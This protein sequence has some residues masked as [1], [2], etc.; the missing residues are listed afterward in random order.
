M[1]LKFPVQADIQKAFVS[2]QACWSETSF[3]P[4]E[5]FDH[6][7]WSKQCF[8]QFHQL[9]TKSVFVFVCG[10]K[11]DLSDPHPQSDPYVRLT[12]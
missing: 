11:T 9:F 3:F 1:K 8:H 7:M 5:S 10:H 6:V 2:Q 12:S 4:C